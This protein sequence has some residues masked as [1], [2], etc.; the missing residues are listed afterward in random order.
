[1]QDSVFAAY[2]LS[3]PGIAPADAAEDLGVS[4]RTVRTY[5][6]KANEAMRDFAAIV[7]DRGSGY[8]LDVADRD[9]FEAWSSDAH[10][11]TRDEGVPQAPRDRVDY[12]INDL[13]MRTGWITLEELA[14]ILFVS[15]ATVSNDLKQVAR[16][17]E[18]YGLAIE[19]RPHHGI[20]I[21]GPEMS[22]RL[23]L[24]HHI[25]D[26]LE[27]SG[28]GEGAADCQSILEVV[29]SRDGHAPSQISSGGGCFRART[30]AT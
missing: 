2:I 3:H 1:M 22:K 17:I 26:A 27:S 24:A 9:R 12:L 11:I 18:P 28:A 7:L 30:P 8:H 10:G 15:R 6:H 4:V 14:Q 16:A 23:C 25:A 29:T 19:R 13:L 5:V 21:T 20:R